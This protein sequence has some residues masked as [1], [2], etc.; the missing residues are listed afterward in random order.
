MLKNIA[1][2]MPHLP[3]PAEMRLWDKS[4]ID[5]GIPDNMLMENAARSIFSFL[6]ASF[7]GLAGLPVCL[8]MG[9]G[10]NGGDAAALGRH[11][12]DAGALPLI[13][14]IKAQEDLAGA[15][16][17]HANLAREDGVEFIGIPENPTLQFFW[18]HLWAKFGQAPKI[19]VDGLLGT[20]FHGSLNTRMQAVIDILNTLAAS[21]GAWVLAIDTPSGLNSLTGEASPLA[22]RANA[23]VT[24]AAAKPGL[25]L[26][27][28]RKWTG[29]IH[30]RG[31]GLP[32]GSHLD[33]P[34]SCRLIDGRLLLQP[35]TQPANSYKNAFGHVLVVGGAG[36]TSGAAHLA[37]AAALRAGAGL[38]SACAPAQNLPL[39]KNGW[40]EIMTRNAPPASPTKWP[41]NTDGLFYGIT[42]LVAGPGMGRCAESATFLA[43]ILDDPQRPPT[44]FD[45]DA[46]VIL[47]H[48]PGLAAKI[49][50]R[51]IL[52]PHPGEAAALL[53]CASR[54]IQKDRTNALLELC[55]FS[56]A[57]VILKGAATI[58][59]RT[60]LPVLLCPYDIPQL[61]IGGAGDVLSGCAGALLGLPD[62]KDDTPGAAAMA[63]AMHTV[64][65]LQISRDYPDR[66]ARASRL[67]DAL[68]TARQFVKELNR[69][70]PV[71]DRMPWP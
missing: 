2:G 51:D 20:G 63:I 50:S 59:S 26:P 4:A 36:G 11:L 64:A 43:A 16:A 27:C 15:C 54:D 55:K 52:T 22:V 10:N 8:F 68:A 67:A 58:A 6:D 5:F 17:W 42:S 23:T 32:F 49:T 24:L 69:R 61:A 21:L 13:F 30:V 14:H 40:P 53:G 37:C 57:M 41:D 62:F 48:E 38:V 70:E 18:E 9:A 7:S 45:A 25:L 47:A 56:K 19:I 34:A 35:K 66:G 33:W 71:G 44:V 39:I 60:D 1:Q 28:A 12:K 46:L 31:I 65:G 29:D 3:A